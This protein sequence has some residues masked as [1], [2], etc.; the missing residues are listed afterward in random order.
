[1]QAQGI[2]P[3]YI[4]MLSIAYACIATA[5]M[6]LFLAR[7]FGVPISVSN[8]VQQELDRVLRDETIVSSG[9]PDK[10]QKIKGE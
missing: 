2:E 6:V 1:M 8:N 3:Q 7:R 4:I 9:E 5:V 10:I